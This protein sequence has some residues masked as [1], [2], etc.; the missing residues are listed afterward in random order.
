MQMNMRGNHVPIWGTC[1]GFEQIIFGA[2]PLAKQLSIKRIKA[3]SYN[4]RLTLSWNFTNYA[5]SS[6]SKYLRQ[7]SLVE[8]TKNP[9]MYFAHRWAFT[10]QDLN[11]IPVF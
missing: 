8:S 7:E 2:I 5:K 10:P 11:N 9:I 3:H 6:I 4:H 1:L